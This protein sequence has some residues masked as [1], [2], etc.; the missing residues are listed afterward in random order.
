MKMPA[1]AAA[2]FLVI[3]T[4]AFAQVR[5]LVA[6]RAEGPGDPQQIVC[7]RES[8]TGSR[9]AQQRVC[10]TRAEWAEYRAQARN[11]VDRV[12]YFRP[13]CDPACLPDPRLGGN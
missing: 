7:V 5:S 9:I 3:G 12:Q 4:A 6:D 8:I 13:S 2:A 10:R 11:T 1:T